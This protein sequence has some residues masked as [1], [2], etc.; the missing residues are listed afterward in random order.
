MSDTNTAQSLSDLKNVVDGTVAV[1][2]AEKVGVDPATFPDPKIDDLGRSYATGKRKNSIAR[3]WIKP[4]NGKIVTNS[5]DVNKDVDVGGG[6]NI[7]GM[8]SLKQHQIK[9]NSI[10]NIDGTVSYL[11]IELS[12]DH[13]D[14]VINGVINVNGEKDTKPGQIILIHNT[15]TI[16][17]KLGTS[18]KAIIPPNTLLMFVYT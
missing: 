15:D 1:A 7:N 12:D 8:L 5:I 11:E 2:G 10:I 3:V 17:Y 13:D 6:V 18:D 14:N 9:G 4:G 16:A